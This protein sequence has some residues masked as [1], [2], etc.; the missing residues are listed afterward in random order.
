[1]A[2]AAARPSS[3]A[4]TAR[5]TSRPTQKPEPSSPRSQPRPSEIATTSPSATRTAA[6]PVPDTIA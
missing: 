3:S 4:A 1:M 2:V 5:T 6:A